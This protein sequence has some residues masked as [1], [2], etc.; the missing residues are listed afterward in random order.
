MRRILLAIRVFFLTLFQAAVAERVERALGDESPSAAPEQKPRAKPQPTALKPRARSEALT[1][2]AALQR[3]AR[4]VDF[5]QEP[6]EGYADA[7]IGAAARDV[8]RGCR[9]VFE[10]LFDLRA[11]VD[12]EEGSAIEVAAGFDAGRYRLVGN[13][14]GEPPFRGK[15]AHHG[16]EAGKCELPAWTGTASAA[17]IVAPVEVE[18][19]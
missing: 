19:G 8:H 12:D 3:E 5:I 11:V 6:L 9:A 17:R 1:L 2:L 18:L 16:W 14:G 13:V 15:L 7:Q 10:R 4:F